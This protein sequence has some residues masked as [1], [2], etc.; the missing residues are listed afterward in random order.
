MNRAPVV[1]RNTLYYT[2]M[3]V[4]DVIYLEITCNV[5]RGFRKRLVCKIY[6]KFERL[7]NDTSAHHLE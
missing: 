2:Y 1:T 6:Y 3:I 4:S 7:I 5:A